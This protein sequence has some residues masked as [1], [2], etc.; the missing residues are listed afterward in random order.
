MTAGKRVA[1]ANKETLVLAGGLFIAAVLMVSLGVSG[2]SGVI[3][4]LGVAAVVCVSSA[5]AGEMLQDL[6]AGHILGGTAGETFDVSLFAADGGTGR[7]LEDVHDRRR[8]GADARGT[9]GR[10]RPAP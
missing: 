4:V 8:C 5:V 9:R 7:G 3:A 1:L 2:T 10:A 6:K